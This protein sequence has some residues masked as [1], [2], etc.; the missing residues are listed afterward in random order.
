MKHA[1]PFVS[2]SSARGTACPRVALLGW[3]RPA[4][5]PQYVPDETRGRSIETS[6]RTRL[7][8]VMA[9]QA[10]GAPIAPDGTVKKEVPWRAQCS[11]QSGEPSRIPVRT[12]GDEDLRSSL[13]QGWE[14]F[15]DLRGD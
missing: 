2:R 9:S 5:R 15:R 10:P 1:K 6:H 7:D 12:I 3:L 14:D 4:M 8:Y 11:G 13:R